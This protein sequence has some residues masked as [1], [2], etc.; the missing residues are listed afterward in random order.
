[1]YRLGRQ[2]GREFLTLRTL[3]GSADVL[4]YDFREN[5]EKCPPSNLRSFS[6]LKIAQ[7]ISVQQRIR[8]SKPGGQAC[9]EQAGPLGKL[10]LQFRGGLALVG[11]D[12]IVE[13]VTPCNFASIVPIL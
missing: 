1:M 10:L 8:E 7:F 6:A 3:L 2:E 13:D 9:Q 12:E 11:L 5:Q 4:I